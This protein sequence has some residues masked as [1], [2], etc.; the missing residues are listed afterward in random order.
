MQVP[1]TQFTGVSVSSGWKLCRVA[2]QPSSTLFLRWF[3][4]YRLTET[5]H[6]RRNLLPI[7]TTP[8][9]YTVLA[10]QL[11]DEPRRF[12]LTRLDVA[13]GVVPV[14]PFMEGRS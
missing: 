8:A 2:L 13:E 10:D 12:L 11:D 14:F 1:S 9:L 6:V 3:F 7:L 4:Q 5:L